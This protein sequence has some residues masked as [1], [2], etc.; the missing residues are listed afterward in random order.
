MK[1]QHFAFHV[2]FVEKSA[3]SGIMHYSVGPMHCSVGPMHCLHD[4]QTSFFNKIFIKNGSHGAIH[5]FKNYFA[6]VFSVFSKI[7]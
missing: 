7:K 1:T 4:L 6:T 3:I 5:T 2:F